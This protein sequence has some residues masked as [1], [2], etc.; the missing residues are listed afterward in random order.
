MSKLFGFSRREAFVFCCL[1]LV[2]IFVSG[3]GDTKKVDVLGKYVR[4]GS[5][6]DET[7]FIREDG[8][9]TQYIYCSDGKTWEMTNK[10][11][12]LPRGIKFEQF[13]TTYDVEK[14]RSIIPPQLG[15]ARIAFYKS[16]TL[17]LSDEG[18]YFYIK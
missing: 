3:C 4:S 6:V 5:G 17:I 1:I 2:C 18:N 14:S 16:G 8:T 15:Y 9:F 10:W 12:L 13:Y 7:L 11:E